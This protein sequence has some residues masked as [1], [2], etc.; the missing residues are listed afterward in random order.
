MRHLTYAVDV[1]RCNGWWNT[2]RLPHDVQGQKCYDRWHSGGVHYIVAVSIF[3]MVQRH[4]LT[5]AD[6]AQASRTSLTQLL[7]TIAGSSSRR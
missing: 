1:V 3:S 4:M 5:F 2:D 7:A 6:E